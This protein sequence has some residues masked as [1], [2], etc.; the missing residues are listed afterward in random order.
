LSGC[1]QL[2]RAGVPLL[3][4]H[5]SYHAKHCLH[6][7]KEAMQK[8]ILVLYMPSPILTISTSYHYQVA[9]LPVPQIRTWIL[10]IQPSRASPFPG[11][12]TQPTGNPSVLPHKINVQHP[13]V[14]QCPMKVR[15]T[16]SG[17][18][19]LRAPGAHKS[20]RVLTRQNPPLIGLHHHL[21]L[22]PRRRSLRLV[23]IQIAKTL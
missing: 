17:N 16:A 23:A 21:F 15:R 3:S 11:N 5:H 22:R 18:A 1:C 19:L 12:S 8:V 14:L 7:Y 4:Q 9:D 6:Q 2:I 20:Q 13:I 10:Q